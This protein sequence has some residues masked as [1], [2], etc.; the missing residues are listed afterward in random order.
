[1]KTKRQKALWTVIYLTLYAVLTYKALDYFYSAGDRA[2]YPYVIMGCGLFVLLHILLQSLRIMPVWIALIVNGLLVL[3]TLSLELSA[4]F[5]GLYY[6]G[7]FSLVLYFA[8]QP[9]M[10][11]AAEFAGS[12]MF[13]MMLLPLAVSAPFLWRDVRRR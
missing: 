12:S 1:M 3:M 10:L 6:F 9:F 13:W 4:L 11:L 8:L 7:D 5:P 2:A